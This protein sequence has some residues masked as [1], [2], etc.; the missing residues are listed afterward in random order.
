MPIVY[1]SYIPPY[2]F[3]N[4][5]ISTV[6]SGIIRRVKNVTQQRERITLKDGD[7]IDLDW[8]YASEPTNKVVILLHGLEGNAQR[9][10]M[11][12]AAKIFN[13][14][15][16]D[17]VC[18]NF[19][20]C[21]GEDNLKFRSYHSGVTEDLEDVINHIISSK[22]HSELFINGFSLGGN[23]ALNSFSQA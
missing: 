12:G 13:Q 18:V 17:A 4:D 2:R 22:H 5:F 3:R 6:Y 19:R 21:S 20:G 23:V 8:S 14:N 7:F 15:N 16:F 10:Y 1:S 9:A 11:L